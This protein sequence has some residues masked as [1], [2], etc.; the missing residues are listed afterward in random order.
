MKRF[1]LTALLALFLCLNVKKVQAGDVQYINSVYTNEPVTLEQALKRPVAVMI[2]T[3]EEAQPSFGIGSAKILYEIMEEGNISRQMAIIDDWEGLPYIGNI[4]STRLY[5][6]QTATEWDPI[7]IHFGGVFYMRER[8]EAGDINNITGT[9]EYGTGGHIKG[10]DAFFR[11]PYKSAPHNAYIDTKLLKSA[12]NKLGYSL[13]LREEY[14]NNKH[15]TFSSDTNILENYANAVNA[16]KINLS[17]IF[18]YSKT[19]FKYNEEEGVY[20]KS[21]HGRPHTDGYTKKQL[22]FTNIIIQN[23]KWNFQ[24]FS[25]YLNFELIDNTETGYYF[26]KGKCIPIIWEKT[27]DYS[28]TVYYD[29]NGNE[30]Q[31]NT[32][33]TYIAIAQKGTAPVIE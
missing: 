22:Q 21:I 15:F 1:Y 32:G 4:R 26:T 29:T 8:L 12:C 5:Y 19:S 6:L 24:P 33:R 25:N 30:I 17:N 20:Y 9:Y 11:I 27:S 18:P 13:S 28:P 31:L 14:Y 23:T 7:L 2:P 10:G 3:D 16:K